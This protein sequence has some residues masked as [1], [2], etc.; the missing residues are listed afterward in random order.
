[1]KNS[2]R[3]LIK[4]LEGLRDNAQKQ[5]DKYR[6]WKGKYTPAFWKKYQHFIDQRLKY[7]IEVIDLKYKE[8][9]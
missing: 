6:D 4:K 5:I 2:N 3:I 7:S 8:G 1:M 9:I